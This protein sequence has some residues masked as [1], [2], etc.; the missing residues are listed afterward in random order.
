MATSWKRQPLSTDERDPGARIVARNL[1]AVPGAEMEEAVLDGEVIGESRVTVLSPAGAV[2]AVTAPGRPA[3]LAGRH[4]AFVAA[5]AVV[6]VRRWHA[7]RTRHERIMRQAELSGNHEAVLAWAQQ[8]ELERQHRSDRRRSRA[9]TF[10]AL[11]KA[12][13]WVIGVLL[14][15]PAVLGIFWAIDRR[16]VTAVGQPYIWAA[17]A[18]AVA[19]SV[20]SAAWTLATIAVPV[21]IVMVLHYL[22]RHP[23]EHAP[24]WAVVAAPEEADRGL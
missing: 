12:A 2:R 9:E 5:G 17:H 11:A 20:A 1:P 22:G 15:S 16:S 19:V 3:R 13:P 14:V 10:I 18:V 23:G 6:A 21:L 8:R 24:A 7:A 4:A